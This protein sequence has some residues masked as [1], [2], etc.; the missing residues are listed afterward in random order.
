MFL[1][2]YSPETVSVPRGGFF[3]GITEATPENAGKTGEIP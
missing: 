2:K 3:D 1:R